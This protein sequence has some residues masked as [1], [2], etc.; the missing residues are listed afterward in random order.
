MKIDIQFEIEGKEVPLHELDQ[1]INSDMLR[2]AVEQMMETVQK[3]LEDTRCDEHGK[4]PTVTIALS[5]ALG[6]RSYVRGCCDY[7]V[8]KATKPLTDALHK[9]AHFGERMNIIFEVR[10]TTKLFIFDADKIKS[11]LVL[12]RRNGEEA[13]ELDLHD[14]EATSK[15]VSRRHASIVW[16]KG[17]L[18]LVDNGS[19]N[20][21]FVNGERLIPYQS[22][23]LQHGDDIR[24]GYLVLRVRF[25]FADQQTR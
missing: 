21:T 22:H 8:D 15:G 13:P 6:L 11:E 2:A 7:L 25:E 10:G 24:L 1:L 14:F 20:G 17:E 12:G 3:Q 9:T 16:E 18:N 23:V 19:H 4:P 5:S